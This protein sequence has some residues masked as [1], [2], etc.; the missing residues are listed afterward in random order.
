MTML[1]IVSFSRS[2]AGAWEQDFT[3]GNQN[4]YVFSIGEWFCNIID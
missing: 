1:S 2:H 4:S 3:M